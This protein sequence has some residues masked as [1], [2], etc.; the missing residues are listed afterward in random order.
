[1][2]LSCNSCGVKGMRTNVV[3]AETFPD[4][5]AIVTAEGR[6]P[7]LK[8]RACDNARISRSVLFGSFWI[9][10]LITLLKSTAHRTRGTRGLTHR[11]R[12][13]ADQDSFASARA[14]MVKLVSA[15]RMRR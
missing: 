7:L 10:D 5:L 4:I 3:Y 9:K 11:L 2:R 15:H 1:M 8:S 12:G 6:Q 14:E 13:N